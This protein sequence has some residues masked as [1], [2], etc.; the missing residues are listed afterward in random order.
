MVGGKTEAGYFR[1]IA[2][3]FGQGLHHG[4][5][6]GEN[7]KGGYS[8]KNTPSIWEGVQKNR[9]KILLMISYNF[10]LYHWWIETIW[11]LRVYLRYRYVIDRV[12]SKSF[13]NKW[14]FLFHIWFLRYSSCS[15][16][17]FFTEIVPEKSNLRENL[18]SWY[19]MISID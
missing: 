11:P 5:R 10:H 19:K 3:A 8:P 16:Y 4:L 15:K 14:F 13:H 12:S 2:F 9:S 18:L 17:S 1:F 6:H 7:A